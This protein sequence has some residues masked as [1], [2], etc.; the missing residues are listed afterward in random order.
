MI[1]VCEGNLRKIFTMFFRSCLR[2]NFLYFINLMGSVMENIKSTISYYFK[3]WFAVAV[4]MLLPVILFGLLLKP[5][6]L[7]EFLYAYPTL[8][9][10]GFSDFF[11][12]IFGFGWIQTVLFLV[13]L[14]VLT[15]CASLLYGKIE[16][17]FRVGKFNFELGSGALNSNALSVF[18]CILLMFVCYF[19]IT[20]L[21]TC[22]MLLVNFIVAVKIGN[23]VLS[24]IIVWI[25]GL[26]NIFL[27]LNAVFILAIACVDMMIMGSPFGVALSNAVQL[28]H[29]NYGES[30]VAFLVP[31]AVFVV[32][33]ILGSL[34]GITLLTNC[35]ALLFFLP[36]VCIY[37]LI[38]VFKRNDM[39]RYDNRQYYNIR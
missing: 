3:N 29:Q 18:W 39:A 4:F 9:L 23:V 5:F 31:M 21:C 13:V 14:L 28:V 24:T 25:I 38:V 17:H 10:A 12:Q 34:I 37:S 19:T 27:V 15:V 11:T 16:S 33:T 1:K 32:L 35:L 8:S 7:I 2:T 22:L 36:Y 20:I 6:G 30:S 26:A